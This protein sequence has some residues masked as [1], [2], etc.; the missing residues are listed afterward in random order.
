[1]KKL[2]CF[3]FFILHSSLVLTSC[4]APM[5]LDDHWSGPSLVIYST[6]DDRV[7]VQRVKIQRTRPISSYGGYDRIW[8]AEVTVSDD[9]GHTYR[10]TWDEESGDYIHTPSS[11][12]AAPGLTLTLD[13]RYDVD[14]DRRPEHYTA[15]STVLRPIPPRDI[16]IEPHSMMGRPG[17]RLTVS[18]TDP[19]GRSFYIFRI[20]KNGTMRSNIGDWHTLGDGMYQNGELNNFPLLFFVPNAPS[21]RQPDGLWFSA[22]DV[23]TI[24]SSNVDEDFRFFV[25]EVKSSDSPSNPLFGGPPYNVRTNISGGAVGFFGTLC[26]AP[27]DVTVP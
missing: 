19:P 8:D 9:A 18:V 7:D 6:I 10:F 17:Y 24:H 21:P 25:D 12:I 22:G 3:S 26:S 27:T 4:T 16:E 11:P 2:I 20:S 15:T 14:G 23:I 1:M 13:V 5:S